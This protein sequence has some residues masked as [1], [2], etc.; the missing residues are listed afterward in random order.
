MGCS[1]DYS[2]EVEKDPINPPYKDEDSSSSEEDI[3]DFEE[4]ESK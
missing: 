3:P 2:I 4:Y 1:N